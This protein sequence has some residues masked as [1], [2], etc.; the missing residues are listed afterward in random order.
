MTANIFTCCVTL[1]TV[2]LVQAGETELRR[3]A[4]ALD[5]LLSALLSDARCPDAL[6]LSA[7]GIAN[8]VFTDTLTSPPPP[9]SENQSDLCFCLT[10]LNLQA[11]LSSAV[12]V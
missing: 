7:S 2:Q 4:A 5:W 6:L 11:Q 3:P 8:P 12:A 9:S 10:V 1:A